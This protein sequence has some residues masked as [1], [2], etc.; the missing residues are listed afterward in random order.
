MHGRKPTFDGWLEQGDILY[1]PRGFIH[2]AHTDPSSYSHHVTVSCCR[3]NTLSDLLQTALHDIMDVLT[4]KCAYLRSSLPPL[5]LD[6]AGVATIHYDGMET[7]EEKVVSKFDTIGQMVQDEL[8]ENI[9][10]FVDSM[11]NEFMRQALPP[12]LSPEESELIYGS[13]GMD[14]LKQKEFTPRT[15]VRLVRKHAQRLFFESEESAFIGH[16]MANSRIYEGRPEAQIDFP[17]E[18]CITL[19]IISMRPCFSWRLDGDL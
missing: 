3:K 12:L 6:M 15:E 4:A 18:V 17:L 8:E 2:Q 1:L 10:S 13:L 16:R 14:P 9:P 11:A 19:A 7:F 5:T